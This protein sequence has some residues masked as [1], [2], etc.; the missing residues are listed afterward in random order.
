MNNVLEKQAAIT[1]KRREQLVGWFTRLNYQYT[2]P[3]E[4]D[5]LFSVYCVGFEIKD[6]KTNFDK[7]VKGRLC[8]LAEK[9]GDITKAK[10][11][12]AAARKDAPTVPN[13]DYWI[14][15]RKDGVDQVR[16]VA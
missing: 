12:I 3:K 5:G 2:L 10:R 16:K 1:N 14:C 6:G 13:F 9:R 15:Y 4:I 7:P 8:F 11:R